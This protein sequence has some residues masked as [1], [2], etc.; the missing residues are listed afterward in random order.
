[1]TKPSR[2]ILK[3][4]IRVLEAENARLRRWEDRPG[5]TGPDG[6]VYTDEA[7]VAGATKVKHEML[8]RGEDR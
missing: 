7:T 3:A 8:G 1:M 4:R 2:S 5:Y 6:K